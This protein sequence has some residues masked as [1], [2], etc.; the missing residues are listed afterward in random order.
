VGFP[1][2]LDAGP[3]GRSWY[4]EGLAVAA[5][6]VA[7]VSGEVEA[8][9]RRD[10]PCEVDVPLGLVWVFLE[11]F[12]GLLEQYAYS[13]DCDSFGL[14]VGHVLVL[15]GFSFFAGSGRIYKR[16]VGCGFWSGVGQSGQP[17]GLI[18]PRSVVQI[19]PPLPSSVWFACCA[20]DPVPPSPVFSFR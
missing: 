20:R 5:D 6:P 11:G 15:L 2:L 1:T 13:F 18:T 7:E 3:A 17:V 4:E 16:M 10:S 19:Y 9:P 12:F 8:C 14:F